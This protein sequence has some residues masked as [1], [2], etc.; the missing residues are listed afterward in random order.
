[1]QRAGIISEFVCVFLIAPLRS[2]GL[3]SSQDAADITKFLNTRDPIWS[4]MTTSLRTS[5]DCKV[6]VIDNIGSDNARFRRFLAHRKVIVNDWVQYLVGR[7]YHNSA[8]DRT[9]IQTYNAMNVSFQEHGAPLDLETLVFQSKDNACGIFVVGDGGQ[10]TTFELRV[11][12]SSILTVN[13]TECFK[14][15]EEM[16]TKQAKVKVTYHSDCQ[17]TLI[18]INNIVPGGNTDNGA[19]GSSALNPTQ[20]FFFPHTFLFFNPFRAAAVFLPSWLT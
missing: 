5:Y 15:Y 13:G 8:R 19:V 4:Y 1:M 10:E 20:P 6:D 9:N 2:D 7:F 17:S 3:I 12:N 14:P 11:K 18:G 16:V